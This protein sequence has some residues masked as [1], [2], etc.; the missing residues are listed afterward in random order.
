[1]LNIVLLLCC[2]ALPVQGCA[3][4]KAPEAGGLSYLWTRVT[5]GAEF[6]V[7]YNY[8][9][10]VVDGAMLAIHEG[11]WVS[12]DG[13]NWTKTALPESG[14]KPAYQKYVQFKGAIYGLGSMQGNYLDM[15]LSS[16]ILRTRDL[17]SWETV[18][19]RSNLPPRVW[20]GAVVFKNEILLVGGWDGERYYNDVWASTDG[21]NWKRRAETTAWSPRTVSTLVVFRDRLWLIGG[22]VVDGERNSNANSTNEIWSTADGINWELMTERWS[23]DPVHIGAYSAAVFD[24][25]LWLAGANRS[26]EFG[27]GVLYSNDGVTWN[28]MAAPWSPRG[29]VAVWVVGDTLYLTGGKS[30][31]MENGQIKFVYSNDVWTMKRPGAE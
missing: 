15:T 2:L 14:L 29:G 18:A 24:G 6:P 8:P 25:K 17:Q 28:E 10:F 19:E 26:N 9:V 22:G 5:P 31:H 3:Q 21:A 30:S 7:G 16:K 20:Y 4:P 1:M 23:K 13:S 12:R 11:G 27:S